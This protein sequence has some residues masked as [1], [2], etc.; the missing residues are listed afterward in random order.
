MSIQ[1]VLFPRED[2]TP[3]QARYWLQKHNLVPIK[4]VHPTPNYLRYR[5]ETPRVTKK[6][7]SKILPNGII[8]VI[9]T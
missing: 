1:A 9:H 6:Y 3:Q 7:Y 8:L 5:I 2:F 4:M